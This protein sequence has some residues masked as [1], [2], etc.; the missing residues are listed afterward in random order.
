[1]R[2]MHRADP[3]FQKLHEDVRDL[4]D[5][6]SMVGAKLKGVGELFEQ[7]NNNIVILADQGSKLEK[8]MEKAESNLRKVE[9]V[10]SKL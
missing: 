10:P 3:T 6:Y 7:Q 9:K 1:M 2:H 8:R 5:A 4:N